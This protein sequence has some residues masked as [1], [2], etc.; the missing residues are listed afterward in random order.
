MPPSPGLADHARAPDLA[1]LAPRKHNTTHIEK[2]TGDLLYSVW[3]QAQQANAAMHQ[4]LNDAHLK[5]YTP[6][7]ETLQQMQE[8]QKQQEQQRGSGIHFLPRNWLLNL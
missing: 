5:C 2:L 7:Q 4:A 3:P 6:D 1:A 8:M